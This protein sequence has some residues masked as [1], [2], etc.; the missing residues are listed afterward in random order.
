MANP[1]TWQNVTQDATAAYVAGNL[2]KNAEASFTGGAGAITGA[3]DQF[4]KD[5]SQANTAAYE[6]E[7][8]KYTTPEA[9][10]AAQDSGVLA[11]LGKQFGLQMDQNVLKNG[12][13]E[14]MARNDATAMRGIQTPTERLKL[15]LETAAQDQG[16]KVTAAGDTSNTSRAALAGTLATNSRNAVLDNEFNS[17]AAVANR[18][19]ILKAAGGTTAATLTDQA[20]TVNFDT[21]SREISAG[22]NALTQLRDLP[23]GHPNKL[24]EKD[25]NQKINQ[26]IL[27]SGK[28]NNLTQ[29]QI[30]KQM[31]QTGLTM[32][33]TPITGVRA[34]EQARAV[35]LQQTITDRASKNTEYYQETQR[36]K[37]ANEEALS[38]YI[39]T[40]FNKDGWFDSNP[41]KAKTLLNSYLGKSVEVDGRMQVITPS[42][43]IA[44][45]KSGT[46]DTNWFSS[47][48]SVGK[49]KLDDAI[50]EVVNRSGFKQAFGITEALNAGNHAA[51]LKALN[52]K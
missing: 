1:I 3:Y 32:N 4:Q 34:A 20:D 35:A 23:E 49:S 5:R 16:M 41:Q 26:L 25:A 8:A 6:A 7:L 21:A 2:M 37:L 45:L 18:V 52:I 24:S 39:D 19:A 11:S 38:T 13:T 31:E 10:K 17:P 42:I 46:A 47:S 22:V 48:P 9:L 33:G 51:L 15:A 12:A 50:K 27:D 30:T 40:N 29:A 28:R 44:V 36:P 43:L 14:A